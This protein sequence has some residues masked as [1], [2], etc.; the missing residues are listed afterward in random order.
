MTR[1]QIWNAA[2]AAFAVWAASTVGLVIAAIWVQGG[3]GGKLILTGLVLFATGLSFA[4]A[5]MPDVSE[6]RRWRDADPNWDPE[7]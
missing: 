1:R 7:Q 2:W 6:F 3:V 5:T 4:I